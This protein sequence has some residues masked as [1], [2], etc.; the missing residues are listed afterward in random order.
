MSD[1]VKTGPGS[2]GSLP[3]ADPNYIAYLY[4][5]YLAAVADRDQKQIIYYE[6][7][8]ILSQVTATTHA[9]PAE[10]TNAVQAAQIEV[11][12][13]MENLL[14]AAD[15]ITVIVNTY[16]LYMQSHS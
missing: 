12:M 16:M 11:Q 8:T 1:S 4:S 3:P 6:K 9:T 5:Q 7:V 10:H 15:Y 13:A 2:G 14:R